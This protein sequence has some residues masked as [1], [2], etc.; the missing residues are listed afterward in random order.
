VDTV[1]CWWHHLAPSTLAQWVGAVATSLAV[2]VALFKDSILHYFRQPKLKVRLSPTP[3]DTVYTPLATW[4]GDKKTWDGHAYWLRLW[5]Q[6]EGAEPAQQVQVFVS[7]LYRQET[8]G[9]YKTI[10]DFM[11]MNLRWSNGRDWKN[12]EVFAPS[13][14]RQPLG[15][16]CDLCSI[17]EPTNPSNYLEGYER[18]C[19]ASLTLEVFPSSGRHRLPPGHIYFLELILSAVNAKPVVV[20]ARLSL[21]G[22]WSPDLAIMLRDHVGIQIFNARPAELPPPQS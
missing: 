8:S 15:K 4:D 12:P 7:K 19:I 6:N 2:I 14:S 18:K 20:Y 16:H 21:D 13:I 1:Y 10:D 22:K 11:P 3:P 17:S 9:E 5:I